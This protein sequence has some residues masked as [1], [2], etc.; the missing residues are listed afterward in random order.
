M[1]G[2]QVAL[3][4]MQWIFNFA[5]SVVDMNA[6]CT[7][8]Y[9]L[10]PIKMKTIQDL[11]NELTDL[12]FAMLDNIVG[13]YDM[14]NNICYN[15]KLTATEK[16]VVGSLVKKGFVYDSF[17]NFQDDLAQDMPKGN[18][19]PNDVVLDAYGLPYYGKVN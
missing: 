16:G 2:G 9:H 8:G 4:F 10:K 3:F 13:Y 14:L 11:K 19:F 15:Y 7:F 6:L 17:G 12:E 1:E 18:F 5:H